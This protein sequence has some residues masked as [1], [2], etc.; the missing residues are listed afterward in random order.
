[1]QPT[2]VGRDPRYRDGSGA[3]EVVYRIPLSRGAASVVARLHYQ[4]IPPYYL[5]DRFSTGRGEETRRL[6]YL[7]SR[8]KVGGTPIDGW[9]FTIADARAPVSR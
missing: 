6:Y 2:A 1:M 8:L 7:T 5:R 4:S 3:D 9:V